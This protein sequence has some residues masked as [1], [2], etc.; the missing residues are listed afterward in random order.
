MEKPVILCYN[1]G[2]S[3]RKGCAGMKFKKE[4]PLA[5][6]EA[7][8][9]RSLGVQ[10]AQQALAVCRK[11]AGET[12]NL[13]RYEDEWTMTLEQEAAY[14]KKTE[15]DPKSLTLGAFLGDTLVGI[16][17]FAPCAAID[18]ARHR[19]SLGIC[20]LKAYWGRGIGTALMQTLI[21][22]VRKTAVEQLE[23]EVVATNAR[24]IRLY[25]R[26]GFAEFGRHPR[27][28]KYRDGT[29]ADMVLMML[30]LRDKP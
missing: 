8:L 2:K 20:I 26:F 30:D 17:S 15:E 11:T 22:E 14:L 28:L 29:Y 18:R 3:I 21:D 13:I 1:D 25:E 6:G 27:K 5:G 7:L 10:D 24:A 9:L 19:A 12:L 23:L 4:I 16:A